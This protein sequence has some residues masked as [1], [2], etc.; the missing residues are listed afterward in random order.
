MNRN[1]YVKYLFLAVFMISISTAAIS[2]AQD[3]L[4]ICNKNVSQDALSR[5]E[6]QQIFLG[7]KTRWSDDQKISFAVM[8][9]GDI[10]N[11]FLKKMVDKTPSQYEAFW[12]KLI[13]S[14]QGKAP[15]SFNTPEEILAY[16]AATPGAVSYVPSDLLQENVKVINIK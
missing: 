1:V 5:D 9:S 4:I 6:L 14:G 2:S 8:K 11:E 13:F 15:V 7:R 12:K 10:H 16:V 3:I